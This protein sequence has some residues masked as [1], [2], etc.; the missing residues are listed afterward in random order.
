MAFEVY[1]HL[2]EYY[3]TKDNKFLGVVTS[4]EDMPADR[5]PGWF[6]RQAFTTTEQIELT[7]PKKIIKAGMKVFTLVYPLCKGKTKINHY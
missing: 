6:G 1:G 2:I 4:L 5:I 3:Q 7:Q